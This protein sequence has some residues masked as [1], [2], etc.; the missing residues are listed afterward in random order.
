MN[1]IEIAN[2]ALMA[3]G[4]SEAQANRILR[5]YLAAI[6]KRKDPLVEAFARAVANQMHRIA[7]ESIK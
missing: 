5:R 2:R 7:L 6:D 3:Y 4:Y 1:R